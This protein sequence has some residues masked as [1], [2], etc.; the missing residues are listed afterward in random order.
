MKGAFDDPIIKEALKNVA[1]PE[2]AKRAATAIE[3]NR[4]AQKRNHANNGYNGPNGYNNNAGF[5]GNNNNSAN[6]QRQ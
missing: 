1:D 2:A 6:G 5:G 3:A 4:D